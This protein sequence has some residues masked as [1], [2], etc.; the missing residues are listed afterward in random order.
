MRLELDGQPID[1]SLVTYNPGVGFGK[2]KSETI[3]VHR[4]ELFMDRAVIIAD[5]SD[6]YRVVRDE[7]RVDDEEHGE[8]SDFTATGYSGLEGAFDSPATLAEI[9]DTY[10][11]RELLELYVTRRERFVYVIN[12]VDRVT[13]SPEGILYEGRCFRRIRDDASQIPGRG[14]AVSAWGSRRITGL[15]L[16]AIQAGGVAALLIVALLGWFSVPAVR[17][18]ATGVAV[19]LLASL[20]IWRG[21]PEGRWLRMSVYGGMGAAAGA[22]LGDILF[23]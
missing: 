10:F 21:D 4:Y 13:V 9:I 2:F 23:R 22:W 12:S 16:G 18:V 7:I 11:C 5:L 8:I 19:A 3:A 6:A 14:A 1:P 20:F 15:A 17:V